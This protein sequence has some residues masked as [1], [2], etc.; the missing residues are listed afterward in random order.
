MLE[1][2]GGC[3]K[4]ENPECSTGSKWLQEVKKNEGH[5]TPSPNISMRVPSWKAI[6]NDKGEVNVTS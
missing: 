2:Y 1:N 5:V 3:K 6:V 4:T